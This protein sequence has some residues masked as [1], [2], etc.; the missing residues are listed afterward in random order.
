MLRG[1]LCLPR[2]G[3]QAVPEQLAAA[4]PPGTIRLQTAVSA[5]TSEGVVLADGSE[6]PADA[7]VVATGAEAAAALLPGLNVPATRTVTTLYHAAP[8]P[9][10]AEPVLLVDTERE[11]LHTSVLSEVT[12][13]YASDSRALVSTS[14]LGG[15]HAGLEAAVRGRLGVLYQTDTSGWEHLSTCTVEG[16]LPAMLPPWPL[17]RG[18]RAGP[19][20]YVCG[21]HRAT[22]SVQGALASGTRAAR[23]V[24]GAGFAQLSSAA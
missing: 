21:D 14:V 22:G 4:L 16:A 1:S 7:V 12:P 24:L 15:G 6:R 17:T 18:S 20:R 11:V 10:L 13:G 3:I 9:P 19:G 2:H 5:L 23:E 8:T